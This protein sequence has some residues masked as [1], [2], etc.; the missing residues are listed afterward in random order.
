[1]LGA[2]SDIAILQHGYRHVNHATGTDRKSELG[3][4]RPLIEIIDQLKAGRLL[5]QSLLGDGVLPVLVPPWNRIDRRVVAGLPDIGFRG[6][7]GFQARLKR[8]A[9]PGLAQ[10]NTHVDIIDWRGLR[11]FR[12]TEAVLNSLC[13]HLAA[14]RTGAVDAAEPTGLLTHHMAHDDACWNFIE[15]L[16]EKTSFG[17]NLWE[18]A[19]G[20]FPS[21]ADL[22]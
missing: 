11:G 8:D 3:S 17:A 20:I 18:S 4:H 1:M 16:L 13:D 10:V 9:A 14:R 21:R 12:G 6:I 19:T 22:R 2:G 5:L 15:T 7:S